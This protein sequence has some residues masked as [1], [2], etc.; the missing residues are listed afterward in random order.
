MTDHLQLCKA[1][2]INLRSTGSRLEDSLVWACCVDKDHNQMM[3][4]YRQRNSSKPEEKG[5]IRV[6]GVKVGASR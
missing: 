1:V 2:E 6:G 4:R 3:R 5:K